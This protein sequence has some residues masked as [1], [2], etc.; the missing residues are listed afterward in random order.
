MLSFRIISFLIICSLQP[1]NYHS[2][3]DHIPPLVTSDAKEKVIKNLSEN[4][5]SKNNIGLHFTE[6][7]IKIWRQRA[8]K[9]PYR[10]TGD[11]STNSPGDWERVTRN[12][13]SFIKN[14]EKEL[15]KGDTINKGCVQKNSAE[16][17]YNGINLKDAAFVF[18]INEEKEYGSIVKKILLAQAKEP[19]TDFSD[20]S[21]WCDNV[22][23]DINPSFLIAEWLT[24]LLF[25][26]DYSKNIFNAEE[27]IIMDR[28]FKDAAYFFRNNL[29]SDFDRVFKNRP[30][31]DYTLSKYAIGSR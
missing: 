15:W 18:L 13:I 9:G 10:K 8:Q 7:E 11:V 20:K 16:P 23:H 4:E 2:T 22:L 25:A 27:K 28:W 6:E 26:Y 30:K 17:I 21:R 19:L 14:P 31:G 5:H 1:L 29:E 24:R 3:I 12:A